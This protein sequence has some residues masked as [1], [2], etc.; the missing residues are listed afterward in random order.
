MTCH[1]AGRC[2]DFRSTIERNMACTKETPPDPRGGLAEAHSRKARS[3]FTYFVPFLLLTAT[4]R[5]ETRRDSA[6]ERMQAPA[7]K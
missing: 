4:R 2:E 5:N 3:A 1:H 6:A 7:D